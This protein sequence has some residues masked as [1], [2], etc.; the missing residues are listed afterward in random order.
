MNLYK[1]RENLNQSSLSV[2]LSAITS[3]IAFIS[4]SIG[5]F[6]SFS[7]FLEAA[8]IMLCGS[9]FYI[10]SNSSLLLKNITIIMLR[11]ARP[12]MTTI[13]IG[14]SSSLTNGAPIVQLFETRTMMFIPVAFLLNGM[15]RSSWKADYTTAVKPTYIERHMNTRAT[16]IEMLKNVASL[17]GSWNIKTF[18]CTR[19]IYVAAKSV[20][21]WQ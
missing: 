8:D 4:L 16:G 1:T 7:S 12:I 13:G 10:W 20:H 6:F 5:M 11:I 21:I 2:S 18:S 3:S 14:S 17:A 9:I 15:T 19:T